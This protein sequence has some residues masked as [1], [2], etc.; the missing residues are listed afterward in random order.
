METLGK[1]IKAGLI[2]DRD[3]DLSL[4]LTC[5]VIEEKI[6]LKQQIDKGG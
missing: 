4:G 1:A 6:K 2:R 5:S 3:K